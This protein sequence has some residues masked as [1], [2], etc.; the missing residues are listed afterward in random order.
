MH[1]PLVVVAVN[2][3]QVTGEPD[4]GVAVSVTTAPET[5]DETV[6]VGVS[7]EVLLSVLLVPRSEAASRSGVPGAANGV[8]ETAAEEFEKLRLPLGP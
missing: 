1:D 8:T 4:A 7:S 3:A 2:A 5:R 6:K